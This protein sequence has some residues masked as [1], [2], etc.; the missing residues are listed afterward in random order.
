MRTSWPDWHMFN[1]REYDWLREAEQY[2][3]ARLAK[4]E[5]ESHRLTLRDV[6][7]FLR[8]GK[9]NTPDDDTHGNKAA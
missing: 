7:K 3:L 2:R 9:D 8:G 1:D 4:S 6:I 5:D